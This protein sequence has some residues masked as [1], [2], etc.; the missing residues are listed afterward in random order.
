MKVSE[1]SQ[2]EVLRTGVGPAVHFGRTVRR[3]EERR[4]RGLFRLTA[5][6]VIRLVEN[7]E[8]KGIICGEHSVSDTR[9]AG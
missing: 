8:P 9:H 7:A 4:P 2:G 5:T 3:G 6:R 1:S